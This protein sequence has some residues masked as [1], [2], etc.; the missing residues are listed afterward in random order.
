MTYLDGGDIFTSLGLG[1]FVLKCLV[2]YAAVQ[3]ASTVLP[4]AISYAYNKVTD[5]LLAYKP[6][7]I[8]DNSEQLSAY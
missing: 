7:P 4:A 1:G 3:V 5:L 8:D 2:V 6:M